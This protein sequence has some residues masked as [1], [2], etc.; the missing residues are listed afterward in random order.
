MEGLQPPEGGEAGGGK[1]P[2]GRGK[3][4]DAL[5]RSELGRPVLD[6]VLR[7]GD[8]LFLPAGFP[9][10]TDTAIIAPTAAAAD[11]DGDGRET[12]SVHLTL[13]LDAHVWR[14]TPLHTRS[15]VLRRSGQ[16]A[17]FTAAPS[18]GAEW[19]AVM[20]LPVGFLARGMDGDMCEGDKFR[21][22]GN[23]GAL[24]AE[25]YVRAFV[26]GLKSVASPRY[27]RDH[28]SFADPDRRRNSPQRP[29]PGQSGTPSCPCRWDS[30][31]AGWT[32]ICARAISSGGRE[33]AA[34]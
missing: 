6:V 1:N 5:T 18:A 29:A 22:K 4:G 19:D 8:V 3:E 16:T 28:S 30:S 31:P 17:K 11:G 26:E 12:T 7:P 27:T 21:R 9:H 20:P 25:A 15:L 24:T 32:G 23:G 14:L 34:R 2:F 13:G 33:M 10:A